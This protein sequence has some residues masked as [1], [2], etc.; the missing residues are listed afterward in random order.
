ML[1]SLM[2]RRLEQL[3][4]GVVVEWRFQK[5]HQTTTCSNSE[6]LQE[7]FSWLEGLP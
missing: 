3:E 1:F 4:E 6:L 5:E 7:D 2:I